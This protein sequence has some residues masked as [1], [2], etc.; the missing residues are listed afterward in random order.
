MN[1][2]SSIEE[3]AQCVRR[4]KQVVATGGGTKRPADDSPARLDLTGLRGIVEYEPSEYTFTALAG[5]P[6]SDIEKALRENGQYL[7]FDPPLS[8]R[9]AT[10]GG[11][12]AAGMSGPGRL[13]YGGL[14]D[15]LIGVR[16]INGGG[17]V[18]QGGGKVVKNAAGFDY[19]KLLCGS[20]GTLGVL[21]EMTFKV[22]PAPQTTQTLEM[23]FPDLPSAVEQLCKITLSQWEADALELSPE[24][25][26]L[27]LRLA[28]NADALEARLPEILQQL[29][30]CA[31]RTLDPDEAALCWEGIQTFEDF[32]E[33]AKILKVPTTPRQVPILDA[34]MADACPSRHYG[35]AGN[36]AWLAAENEAALQSAA[37]TLRELGLSGTVV[38]GTSP[39][40][41][42]GTQGNYAI[43]RA[44]KQVLDPD[45]KFPAFHE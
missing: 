36:V 25:N 35:H 38:R 14:R 37:R 22:F 28:G 41:I 32:P 43:H 2:P 27:L 1:N 17:H 39:P 42:L 12:V 21:V 7:P 45:A 16:F 24:G 34:A 10:L 20:M 13:R 4:S 6:V 9:G 23:T 33:D 18:I 8:T 11:T 40:A 44:I 15:F 30:D 29:Q 5:T 3:A 19:P 31:A 26:R